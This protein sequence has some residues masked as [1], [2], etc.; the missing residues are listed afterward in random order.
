L[1]GKSRSPKDYKDSGPLKKDQRKEE[2]SLRGGGKPQ[3]ARGE[4]ESMPVRHQTRSLLA[5]KLLDYET[6]DLA[7]VSERGLGGVIKKSIK[8]KRTQS[9]APLRRAKG[10]S[11]AKKEHTKSIP[12]GESEKEIEGLG[13]A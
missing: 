4:G 12:K 8:G 11:R 3:K 6:Q 9:G 5:K 10:N 13:G 2:F 7:Q 1:G